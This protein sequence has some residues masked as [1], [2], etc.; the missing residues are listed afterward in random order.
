MKILFVT[1]TPIEMN[2]S[3]MIRNKALI[4]GFIDNGGN[5]DIL[6][7]TGEEYNPYFD[8]D[9]FSNDVNIVRLNNNLHTSIVEI[10]DG[11]LS[12]IKKTILPLIRYLYHLVNLYDSTIFIT[13]KIHYDILPEKYYNIIVSSSDPKSSHIAVNSLIKSGLKY[14]KWIQYWGD[15]FTIDIT[16]RSL[17]P[18]WY[19]QKVEKNI[20]GLADKIVYVSPFTLKEQQKLFFQYK[21]KMFFLPIPYQN[22]KLYK[23]NINNN[24]SIQ[25]G[26]FGDYKSSIRD[27]RPLYNYC[28]RL[29]EKLIIA[30]NSDLTLNSTEQINILPRI[31]Q[32]K[33]NVLES[34]CDILICILNKQ[35][36]QIPGKLYHYAATNKPVMV[37]VDGDKQAE[38][39]KYLDEFN[40]FVLC[41]NNITAIQEHIEYIKKFQIKYKPCKTFNPS[42]IAEEFIRSNNHN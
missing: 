6:T 31:N 32:D 20:I 26:Y 30:G 1:L 33:L 25:L 34:E 38:I 35:G 27:I 18:K 15:P 19:V 2:S 24:E 37:I 23:N 3:A 22:E 41:D 21:N 9:F 10:N 8:S 42:V 39:S 36:T 12:R 5:V 4:K 40:R 29:Q 16:R 14:G 11:I 28:R 17:H 13:H 7:T